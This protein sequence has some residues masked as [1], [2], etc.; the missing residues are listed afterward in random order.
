MVVHRP[1][2]TARLSGSSTLLSDVLSIR[3]IFLGR[4]EKR[5]THERNFM[6]APDAL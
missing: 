1:V 5:S 6:A 4:P 3:L 2:E